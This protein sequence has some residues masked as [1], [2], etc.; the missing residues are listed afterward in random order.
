MSS[1]K[2]LNKL[3]QVIR[4]ID[5]I[6]QYKQYIEEIPAM[7]V[8]LIYKDKVLFAKGYGHADINKKIPVTGKTCFR[9]ASISK[10]FTTVAIMQLVEANKLNLD[11]KV[12]TYLSWFVSGVDATLQ[13]I[14]IRQLLT[15]TSVISRDGDTPHW[16]EHE[17]PDL[18]H[19]KKYISTLRLPFP[20]HSRWKYSNFGFSIL[21]AVIEQVSG[22]TYEEYIHKNICQRLEMTLTSSIL[23]EQIKRHLA[24][25]WGRKICSQKREA[26]PNIE[27]NAMASATGLS[28]CI[29]DLL[30][31]VSSQF[32]ENSILLSDKSKKELLKPHWVNKKDDISQAIGFH[33]FKSGGRT[34]Y[35]HSGGFQGYRCNI[36]FDIK[37]SIGVVT[38]TDVL[39]IDPKDYAKRVFDVINYIGK[40]SFVKNNETLCKYEGVY[41]DIWEDHA[42]MT[43]GNNLICF[44]PNA[45]EPLSH[46]SI[47]EPVK[48]NEFLIKGSDEVE[49]AGELAKYQETKK[50]KR[51]RWGAAYSYKINP[52]EE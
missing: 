35:Y 5:I 13:K 46:A 24:V 17:F 44:D 45:L 49:I 18:D 34:I 26:F 23:T 42:V 2:A 4:I 28:S 30:K 19:I 10:I 15:H 39:G 48:E 22:K 8:G 11:E 52:I 12:T 32:F 47:L 29:N 43:I 7:A 6:Y 3:A 20:I 33:T 50:G 38:L 27:T 36:S 41:R 16:T 25:G 40:N 14:T 31:F 51:F 9:I 21:G 1:D 37:R